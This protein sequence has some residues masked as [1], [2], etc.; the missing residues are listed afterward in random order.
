MLI[1]CVAEW[2][3]SINLITN[4]K[5]EI[6]I[7]KYKCEPIKKN[8]YRFVVFA[9][10]KGKYKGHAIWWN[11]DYSYL[12]TYFDDLLRFLPN[13]IMFHLITPFVRPSPVL[14]KKFSVSSVVSGRM[15][16]EGHPLRHELYFKKDEIKIPAD[17]YLSGNPDTIFE[18]GD[19]KNGLVLKHGSDTSND[20]IRV[21]D[22]MFHIAIETSG[23]RNCFSEKLVDCFLTKTI[24]VFWGCDN[25]G[26]FFNADGIIQCKDVNDIIKTC[27]KLT[28]E[29]YES[30]RAAIEENYNKSLMY[31]DYKEHLKE[32]IQALLDGT[33][34]S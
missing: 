21:F 25:I 19:Y 2:P 27:N 9:E 34:Y 11:H 1:K 24:P 32:T 28:P 8:S 26:D 16:N 13:T 10:E 6:L 5:V 20:K 7:D 4:K 22:C 29:L 17:I 18:K 33:Y 31:A 15:N 23:M 14:E 30:K 3:V 12:L